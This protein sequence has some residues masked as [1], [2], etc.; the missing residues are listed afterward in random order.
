M[1]EKTSFEV[2][3]ELVVAPLYRDRIVWLGKHRADRAAY[4]VRLVDLLI[5][6]T[7]H[8]YLTN[9][10]DPRQLNARQVWALYVQRWTIETS[11]AAVKRSLGLAYLRVTTRTES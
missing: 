11:F 5:A 8:R 4:P 9:V 6:G 10:L 7:W 1:P 3:Q 2:V